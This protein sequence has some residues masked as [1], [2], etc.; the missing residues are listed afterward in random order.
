VAEFDEKLVVRGGIGKWVGGS[1]KNPR[2]T[3]ERTLPSSYT[4]EGGF[5]FRVV[6]GTGVGE[7]CDAAGDKP[8][9]PQNSAKMTSKKSARRPT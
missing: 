2:D 3:I 1:G 5:R 9:S 8:T 4:A 7:G 6:E